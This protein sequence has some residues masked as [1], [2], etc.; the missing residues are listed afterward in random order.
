MT[1]N[2]PYAIPLVH[3]A[4]DIMTPF[5]LAGIGGLF[6]ELSGMLNIALEGLM[7]SGAFFSIV[8]ASATGS[9]LLGIVLGIL[10]SMALA[11]VFGAVTLYLAP[12]CS[13]PG[14]P[15]T[16]LRRVSP[17]CWPFSSSRQK[18]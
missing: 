3:N 11:W 2:S 4:V 18:G 5:L 1:G 12:T 8:C 13:S 7:L 10:C 6:T 16:S 14:L 17:W 15:R 9:L